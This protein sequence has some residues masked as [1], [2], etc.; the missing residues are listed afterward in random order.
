[1]SDK[2]AKSFL[3]PAKHALLKEDPFVIGIALLSAAAH[4]MLRRSSLPSR[5]RNAAA[6]SG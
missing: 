3:Q 5:E 2:D 4:E 1:M 6:A